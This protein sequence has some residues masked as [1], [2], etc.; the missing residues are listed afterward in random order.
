MMSFYDTLKSLE[1]KFFFARKGA[2]K[3]GDPYRMPCR[4]G[5]EVWLE[6][7]A[8]ARKGLVDKLLLC[9]YMIR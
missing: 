6:P 4:L 1:D 3:V 5:K 8:G 9:L 7:P 2:R